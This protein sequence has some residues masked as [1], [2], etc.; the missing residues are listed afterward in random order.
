MKPQYFVQGIFAVAGIIAILA[1]ILNWD[2]FFNAQNA[3]LIVR[4]VGRQRARLFYGALGIILLS[5][6]FFFFLQ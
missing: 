6:S 4:N 1:A 5:M 3:Q 2:W